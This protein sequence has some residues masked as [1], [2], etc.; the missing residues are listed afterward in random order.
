VSDD[1]IRLDLDETALSAERCTKCNICNTACPVLPV[2]DL[3]PGPKYC[4]PQS[5]RFRPGDPVERWVDYCS[6]CGACSR[7]CPSGVQ[8][9]ELNTRARAHAYQATGLPL[10][11]RARNQLLSRSE[12]LGRLGSVASPVANLALRLRPGRVVADRLL[13]VHRDAPLP[14]FAQGSFRRRFRRLPQP[15]RPRRRVAYFQGCT[16]EYY[17]HWVGEAAVRVL[18]RAGVGVDLPPQRC[19]GLPFI[20]NG[21]F[22][23]ARRLAEANLRAL[24]PVARSGTPI[25]ATSTSC[26]LTLKHEYG[27][28]L[29]LRAPEWDELAASVYDVFELLRGMVWEGELEPPAG[30]LASRV[31]YHGPCQLRGHGIGLPAVEL[32][33][34][35][36]GIELAESG[37]ECCGVAGTYGFKSEKYEIARRVG[38]PLR[39][40]ATEHAADVVA[41]DSETC[42]WQIHALTGLPVRHPV[43]LLASAWAVDA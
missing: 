40:R 42:R 6:G 22:A 18:A 26:S 21:D 34:G 33:S 24:L 10:R 37:V 23:G 14:S 20:S 27:S 35:L 1:P 39:H 36:E 3:F 38:D 4:G 8:V 9:A 16:T 7:A 28:V 32:L 19:C 15:E 17:E 29:G 43:E 5:Q 11:L 31:L 30:R 41:C 25:V 12:L 2:T 13:G